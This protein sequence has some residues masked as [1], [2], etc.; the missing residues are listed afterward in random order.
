[1]EG[2]CTLK[3]IKEGIETFLK[4]YPEFENAVAHI[5]YDCGYGSVAIKEPFTIAHTN[6]FSNVRIVSEDDDVVRGGF[7]LVIITR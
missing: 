7:N 2:C 6:S 1:M 5:G 3:Q 4:L